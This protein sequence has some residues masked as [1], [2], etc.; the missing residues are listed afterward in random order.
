VIEPIEVVRADGS[1]QT[2]LSEVDLREVILG[3]PP[4]LLGDVDL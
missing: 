2:E 3:S 1:D 4:S